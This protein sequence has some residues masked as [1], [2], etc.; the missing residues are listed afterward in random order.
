MRSNLYKAS[1]DQTI[2]ILGLGSLLLEEWAKKTCPNLTN[3]RLAKIQGYKRIFNKT[4]S[5]LVRNDL[6]PENSIAYACL[7]AVPSNDTPEMIV[8]SFEIPLSEWAPFVQREFEYRLIQTAFTEIETEEKGRGVL[9]VGDYK[10]DQ[11]CEHIVNADP[12]RLERW[13][14]FRAKYNGPMWR[15]DLLPEPEY[16]KTCLD[17]ARKCG[18]DVFDNFV[19]TTFTGDGRSIRT[20]LKETT[21]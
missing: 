13:K 19:D 5:F 16:L 14:Q 18:D 8:S 10:N 20:Y 1:N 2:T 4:D 15:Y 9:C 6:K 7:S 3:F 17:T 21:L 11:E 12:L